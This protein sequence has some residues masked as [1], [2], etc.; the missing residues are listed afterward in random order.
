MLVFL[1]NIN[2][3]DQA[4]HV[5]IALRGGGGGGIVS[6]F[7]QKGCNFPASPKPFSQDCRSVT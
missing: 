4:K 7:F 1:E 6:L 3:M 2:E 5:D